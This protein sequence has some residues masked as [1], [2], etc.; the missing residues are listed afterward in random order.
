MKLQKL[1]YYAHAWHLA[2]FNKPLISEEVQAWKFG[3]VIP[4]LFSKCSKWKDGNIIGYIDDNGEIP[5][6]DPNDKVA[7]VVID[8]VMEV[9]G[10]LSA[11][12]LSSLAHAPDSAWGRTREY[13]HDGN[14]REYVLPNDLIGITEGEIIKVPN[15]GGTK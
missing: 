13:H 9:Y 7:N 12:K 1:V 11:G 4:K 6:I 5:Y 3:P 15:N 8:K 10:S 2:Y 14:A